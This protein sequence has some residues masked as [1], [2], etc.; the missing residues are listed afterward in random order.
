MNVNA[1]RGKHAGRVNF[2][3]R[4]KV[5]RGKGQLCTFDICLDG[6]NPDAPGR[7]LPI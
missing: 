4:G 5:K 3:A 1:K 7:H 2:E 6:L